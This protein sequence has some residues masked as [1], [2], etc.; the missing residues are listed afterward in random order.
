MLENT[1]C[2][3]PGIGPK[4]ERRLWSA[5]ILSWANA[6]ARAGEVLP[7]QRAG[8]V[9][10]LAEESIERLAAEDARYFHD[11]LPPSEEW[12][13]FPQ[14]R[15]SVAYLD[16]E[17]TGLGP[18][19]DY[20]TTIALYDGASVRYYVQGDNLADFAHD[21]GAYRLLV[22]YNGKGFDVPFIRSSLGIP[23]EQAQID[24]RYV[25]H[26]LGYG[27]GLKGCERR[28][29]LQRGELEGIDGYFAVLLWQDYVENRN[30]GALE[31]LLAYNIQDTVNLETLMVQAY[32]MKVKGT[33]FAGQALP[34]PEPPSV[35]F[36]ADMRTVSRIRN[37]YFA[38]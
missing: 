22:S 9:A 30:D 32:N 34:L 38:F 23:M 31:T 35:P 24:L 17:T 27:G 15:H 33:A 28:L 29:G 6:C 16:I 37:A 13:L 11:R 36:R 3:M 25:L 8:A 5:G 10:R 14:F 19:R 18:P 4:T 26:S 21:V 1:F 2:H 20:I 7:A 12:R